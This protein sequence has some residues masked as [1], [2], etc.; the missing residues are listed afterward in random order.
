M[1]AGTNGF[2][3]PKLVVE[4]FYVALRAHDRPKILSFFADDATFCQHLPASTLPYAGT[5]R[6]REDLASRLDRVYADWD[7]LEVEPSRLFVE[8]AQVDCMLEIAFRLRRTGDIFE[9]SLRHVFDIVH[10]KIYRLDEY[11]DSALL[12]AFLRLNGPP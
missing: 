6:G 10:G 11:P 4:A 3:H 1:P 7:V 12:D 9:G 5:T 8:G 2:P